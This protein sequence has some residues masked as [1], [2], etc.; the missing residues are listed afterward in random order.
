[1]RRKTKILL[2]ILSALTLVMLAGVVFTVIMLNRVQYVSIETAAQTAAAEQQAYAEAIEKGEAE[3]ESDAL[4]DG[5][6][7]LSQEVEQTQLSEEEQAL[8]DIQKAEGEVVNILLMGVDRRGKT[9][10]SRSDTMLIAT[11]DKKNQ[12]LKLTSLMRD[13]YVPIPGKG[14]NRINSACATGGPGLV[15]ETINENFQLDIQNYVLVDFRMFEKIVDQL[16]GITIDMSKGEVAEANDC[17]AG[18]N[19]QRGESLRSGFIK[20]RGGEVTLTGKQALGYCRIRHFGNGD[21][22][23]TSRQ[24]KVLQAIFQVF[25]SAGAIKQTEI[26]YDLLP[27]VE[28]NLTSTQILSLATQS[29]GVAQADIMHFRLPTEG[30]Y[31]AKSI[32]GMSVLLPDIPKNTTALN[33][34]LYNATVIGELEYS[35]TKKGSYYKKVV[36]TPS[37]SPAETPNPEEASLPEN[38]APIGQEGADGV[39]EIPEEDF[40]IVEEIVPEEES[41]AETLAPVVESPAT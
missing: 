12:R 21:Y 30:T 26:L 22:A 31:R 28:T 33:D 39:I 27:M 17:I 16:G 13:M 10:N 40:S 36:Q 9:G 11:L 37:P 4:S 32:R 19:K 20:Q 5:E 24:Y 6:I 15:M 1:M 3:E 25:K 2:G 35:D 7:D 38:V 18:L 14:E 8:L 29:L 23:R 34:F 41:T